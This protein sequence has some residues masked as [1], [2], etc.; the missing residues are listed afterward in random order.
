MPPSDNTMQSASGPIRGGLIH[1]ATYK[2]WV[3]FTVTLSTLL[4]GMSQTSVQVALPPIMTA[5]GLNVDQAQ[6]IV[7]GQVIAGA[8]MVPMVGWLGNR[9][10]NRTLYLLSML[11]FL[12]G[13]TLC[14]VAWSSAS[15]IAFRVLQ[16][17]GGG[18]I[19]PMTLTLLAGAFPPEQR[20]IAVGIMGIGIASSV[21]V[22]PVIGG[23]LTDSISWRMVFLLVLAPGLVCVTLT[24]LILPNTREAQQPSLDVMGLLIMSLFLV[25]LLV[26]LSRG[27]REGWDTSFIQRLLIMAAVSLALFLVWERFAK[28]PLV[29]LRIYMNLTFS[30]VSVLVLLFFM[31]FGN[32]NFLQIV[33]LQRLLEYTP[34]RAGYVMLPG[35][36]AI[37]LTFPIAGR[38]ADLLDRRLIIFCALSL[39]S[40][41]SYKLT[42]L[43]LEQPLS[44]MMWISGMQLVAG[45]FFYT[46]AVATALSQLPP[47]KVRLGSS[48]LNLMQQGFGNTIGVALG[49]TVF[50]HRLEVHRHLLGQQQTSLALGWDESLAPV[51]DFVQRVGSLGHRGESQVTALLHRHL[52]QQA[53]VAAYQDCFG[54]VLI[55]CLT[56]MI[57]LLMLRNM[58]E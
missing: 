19:N 42:F 34:A 15:L 30:A 20:G 28:E 4:V 43:S 38:L 35:A 5:F 31:N 7:I 10:G 49:T 41:A 18:P 1:P 22:G 51:R 16:G 47:E 40:I 29:D 24:V 56:S 54:L 50:Q 21:G 23:Y 2:W 48:L 33:L 27:H 13:S 36:L 32:S 12:A 9:L 57:L 3:A 46:S 8:I 25:S 45:S 6:W 39:F 37:A 26:A 58:Q 14:A 11:T 55:V 52:H 53:A 17:L 44:W